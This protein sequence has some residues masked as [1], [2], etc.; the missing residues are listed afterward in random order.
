MRN[1]LKLSGSVLAVIL[2]GAAFHA[3][4]AKPLT[5]QAEPTVPAARDTSHDTNFCGQIVCTPET[6]CTALCGDL[7]K[8]NP[9]TH[10]CFLD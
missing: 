4:S 5:G 2:A 9:G 3:A 1:I 8:C 6:D 10:H 7:A